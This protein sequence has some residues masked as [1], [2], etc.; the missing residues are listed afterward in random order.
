MGVESAKE[1]MVGDVGGGERQGNDAGMLGKPG[2][3]ALAHLTDTL[4]LHPCVKSRT[5][6]SSPRFAGCSKTSSNL[7]AAVQDCRLSDLLRT[8]PEQLQLADFRYK[9]HKSLL[10][11]FMKL[12]LSRDA[13]ADRQ[14]IKA[15]ECAEEAVHAWKSTKGKTR[16]A[17][18]RYTPYD[19]RHEACVMES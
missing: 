13:F 6:P 1:D 10:S 4:A 9:A 8:V 15:I 18:V 12:L 2:R 16:T 7:F 14:T 5:H 3:R 19:L 17:S 11:I